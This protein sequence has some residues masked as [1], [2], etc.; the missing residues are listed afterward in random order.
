[1]N[2]TN[3]EVISFGAVDGLM[4]V[5][6]VHVQVWKLED[7]IEERL[8]HCTVLRHAITS[9]AS[10]FNCTTHTQEVQSS[11]SFTPESCS[12]I[13]GALE[14]LVDNMVDFSSTGSDEE[15]RIYDC[16]LISAVEAAMWCANKLCSHSL[17]L[18]QECFGFLQMGA[19]VVRVLSF[20][21][22]ILS[23]D[24]RQTSI[25][26]S[27]RNCCRELLR[28]TCITGSVVA[29]RDINLGL[30]LGD[31]G[32]CG[33]VLDV[34]AHCYSDEVLSAEAISALV[35]LTASSRTRTINTPTASEKDASSDVCSNMAPLPQL[36]SSPTKKLSSDSDLLRN[37]S[38]VVSSD[39]VCAFDTIIRALGFHMVQ[40]Q[41]I[42]RKSIINR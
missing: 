36:P 20:C 37:V 22:K 25:T 23:D 31:E 17:S 27:M 26:A 38:H 34:L 13:A 40:H 15:N 18:M 10:L 29:T 8:E 28:V 16:D 41:Q 5:L 6:H 7:G 4:T 2:K 21:N 14:V 24:A 42:A 11:Y 39:P 1:L 9:L 12:I 35:Q 33:G 32:V 19:T 3:Q 30:Q